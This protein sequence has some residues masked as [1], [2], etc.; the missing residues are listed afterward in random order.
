MPRGIQLDLTPAIDRIDVA[1]ILPSP[2]PAYT[3]L[4]VV[5]GQDDDKFEDA[6]EDEDDEDDDDSSLDSEDDDDDE[7][8]GYYEE[9]EW[10]G[11]P[12]IDKELVNDQD[13]ENAGGDLTKRY[14]RLRQHVG[15]LTGEQQRQTSKSTQELL[16]S[17]STPA[18]GSAASSSRM[19]IPAQNQHR[20]RRKTA[21]TAST[22]Q[23]SKDGLNN[24]EAIHASKLDSSLA[25]LS[26]RYA[27]A[28][29]LAP[30]A[31]TSTSSAT[32]GPSNSAAYAAEPS[33]TSNA[34][35]RKGGSERHHVI[36]D[37]SDRAT[38]EQVL[39]PRTRLVLFKMLNRGL[40]EKVEGCVSTGKEANVYHALGRMQPDAEPPSPLVH[41][42]IKIYKTSILTFKSRS[43]YLTGEFRFES[44]Y[45]K[46]KNPRK[47][48]RLWAEK[49]MRNLR[50]LHSCG[51]R[52]PEPVEVRNNVLVMSFLGQ[53]D[54][55]WEAC[56]RLKDAEIPAERMQ[57]LYY[58][59]LGILR[60][61]YK[62]CRL[63]HADLSEYNVIYNP[64]DGHLYTFDVS[65]SVEHDHPHAFDFLRSDIAN[66][67]EF[68]ARRGI[69]TL[70]IKRTFDFTIESWGKNG[71]EDEDEIREEVER[72]FSL[73]A[74]VDEN[75]D[76][77]TEEQ[78]EEA[79]E[80]AE[81][82]DQVFKQS[83]IPRT[84]NEVYDPERDVAR[85]SKG[86]GDQLIYANIAGVVAPKES[87]S[88]AAP[89]KTVR[90]ST[91]EG[92][93]KSS[94]RNEDGEDTSE[95]EGEDEDDSE[96]SGSG[97]GEE[98]EDDE[99]VKVPKGKKFEDKDAK[100]ERK[101]AAK[102]AQREKRKDKIPK[103]VKKAKVKKG[104]GKKK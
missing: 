79:R 94:P 32:A 96:A 30:V 7:E 39:D 76:E 51:I 58:E 53:G 31:S 93:V 97:S 78:A 100:K 29:N 74:A 5:P 38:N 95:E 34:A 66:V 16:P 42:A 83:Y 36:K 59:M 26:Q 54:D 81:A 37:K 85:V 71:E 12:R 89:P 47:L 4:P 72:R 67:D 88:N 10:D 21:T 82:E 46:A 77:H 64:N 20:V 101:Q 98:D 75:G 48:V 65:Q 90:I 69:Q 61:M 52:S 28:L 50:R 55:G 6:I 73:T 49:E 25:Q 57:D 87:A 60:K 24:T 8:N 41:F 2:P 27:S 62:V 56:P 104:S 11:E 102:E 86:E 35:T 70:G 19:P 14:N 99:R 9:E 22:T 40:L 15:A 84:L 18:S 68:F 23:S 45:S 17:K 33:F 63:V 1:E 3:Q 43:K 103:S 80:K 13:W 44:G 92:V 91:D